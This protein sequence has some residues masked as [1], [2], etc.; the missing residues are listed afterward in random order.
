[1][2]IISTLFFIAG[3]IIL[4]WLHT[5]YQLDIRVE[6][7]QQPQNAPLISICVPARNEERNI[8]RCVKALHAQTYANIE[9]IILDDLTKGLLNQYET[10]SPIWKES[11]D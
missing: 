11:L 8:E 9:I 7:A 3:L 4:R 5:Q 10:N 1:M 6:P 2:L